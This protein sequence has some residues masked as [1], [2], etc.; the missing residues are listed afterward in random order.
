MATAYVLINCDMGSE[1]SVINDIKSIPGAKSVNGVFGAYDIIVE[2]QT[3]TIDN[4]RET[5]TMKIRKL[6]GVRTT[7]TLI[8][9]EY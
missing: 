1:E 4:L 9:I 7:L 8:A 3:P 5:I 2:V 6:E